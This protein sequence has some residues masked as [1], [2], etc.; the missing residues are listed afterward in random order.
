MMNRRNFMALSTTAFA[1]TANPSATEARHEG[2]RPQTAGTVQPTGDAPLPLER[3]EPKS[4][5]HL[6][7]THIASSRFPLIDFHTHITA[8]IGTGT[9]HSRGAIQWEMDPENCLAVMDRK[10]VRIMVNLT[11]G[12]G[13]GVREAIGKLQ[14]AHPGRFVVFTE[15]AYVKASDPGYATFQADQIEDAYK[16]GARG[17]KILKTLG[18]YLRERGNNKLIPIDDPRFDQMWEAAER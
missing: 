10:N 12:Y 6:P 7:G 13:Q 9:N 1:L 2:E 11:G 16:A 3:Y 18:L 5:L 8:T 4:M 17:L 15:P 14:D